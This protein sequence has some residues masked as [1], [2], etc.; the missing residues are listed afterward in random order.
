MEPAA[1]GLDNLSRYADVEPALHDCRLN[2]G[3]RVA[4]ILDELPKSER[5]AFQPLVD[6]LT[7]W[8][9]FTD[10]PDHDRLRRLIGLAFT[11][12]M[13]EDLRPTIQAIADDLLD[14]VVGQDQFDV[15][16]ALAFSQPSM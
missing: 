16:G 9:G 2:S 14:D 13:M 8:L 12:R 1:P 5:K 10:P 3:D 11:P 7:K 4:A 15:V 6:H